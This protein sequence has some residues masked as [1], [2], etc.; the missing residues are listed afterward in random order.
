MC[1]VLWVISLLNE[2]DVRLS[3]IPI[4]WCDNTGVVALTENLIQ[5]SKMKHVELDLCF[6]REKV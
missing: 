1:E 5:H 4:V 6:M 3:N 2:F